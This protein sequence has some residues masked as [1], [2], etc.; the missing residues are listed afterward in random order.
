MKRD[1][2][3]KEVLSYLKIII[4]SVAVAFLVNHTL[5]TN[6]A[7]PTGSMENTVLTG[8]RIIVN[9]LA[10][11]VEKPERG[12]I[13]TFYLPDNEKEIFLKRIVGLPGETI[14]G[15]SG[16]V[17]INGQELEESYVKEEI[18]SDFGPYHVPEGFYF[19]MGD[20][21]N[22]SLDSRFWEK[23]FV[24]EDKIIGKAEFEYYPEMKSLRKEN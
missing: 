6:A 4:I 5:I 7:V 13:V 23:K 16:K 17:L 24:S 20:N 19:M 1:A 8:S 11:N 3:L 15:K 9:R 2:I 10:Y 22:N 12:D 18:D 21:R 14:E